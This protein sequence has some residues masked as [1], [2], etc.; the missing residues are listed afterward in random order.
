MGLPLIESRPPSLPLLF[1]MELDHASGLPCLS[2]RTGPCSVRGIPRAGNPSTP[3]PCQGLLCPSGNGAG[4]PMAQV[5]PSCLPPLSLLLATCLALATAASTWAGQCAACPFALLSWSLPGDSARHWLPRLAS[6]P[7][8]GAAEAT[9]FFRASLKFLN[10]P[11][12]DTSRCSLSITALV[13]E[14]GKELE[15]PK[16]EGSLG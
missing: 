4:D 8:A 1:G 12:E 10:R 9:Y 14:E 15:E 16:G 7:Q 2:G 6:N 5:E 11:S 13:W 3:P